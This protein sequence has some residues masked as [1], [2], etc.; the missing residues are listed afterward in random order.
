[1]KMKCDL[2]VSQLPVVQLCT[3]SALIETTLIW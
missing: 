3:L 2:N 1:M